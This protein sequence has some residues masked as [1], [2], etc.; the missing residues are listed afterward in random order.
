MTYTTSEVSAIRPL[1]TIRNLRF[2][3]CQSY[4]HCHQCTITSNTLSVLWG[5]LNVKFSQASW[6]LKWKLLPIWPM[7]THFRLLTTPK[8]SLAGMNDTTCYHWLLLLV[9]I[10]SAPKYEVESIPNLP[11][12]AWVRLATD[13]LGRAYLILEIGLVVLEPKILGTKS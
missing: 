6:T 13:K 3:F 11:V 4:G 2:S 8:T 5:H 7:W 9:F 1:F 10:P 12:K